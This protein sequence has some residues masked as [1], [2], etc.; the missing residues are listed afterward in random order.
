MNFNTNVSNI[1][2]S[3][4]AA[5]PL[6]M[7]LTIQPVSSHSPSI[8]GQWSPFSTPS[9]SPYQSSVSNRSYFQYSA[10]VSPISS[11]SRAFTPKLDGSGGK[12]PIFRSNH[13]AGPSNS[14]EPAAK[15]QLSVKSP[16]FTDRTSHFNNGA[17]FKPAN[18]QPTQS[19][20]FKS[21]NLPFQSPQN[22]VPKRSDQVD[23]SSYIQQAAAQRAM[24][25]RVKICTF[26]KTNG[27]IELIY[28][29]HALKDNDDK[30]TCP[31]LM[32]H[33]CPICG[34]SGEKTHT[35]KYCPVLQKQQRFEML[36]KI[37]Q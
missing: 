16:C 37:A 32:R 13:M 30:I 36:N 27:E 17:Y 4:Q 12:R 5:T 11:S 6:Y 19:P 29:S 22:R 34:A 25:G 21:E 24:G 14:S 7:P 20:R 35:R 1:S 26:C 10:F 8:G 23:M 2:Y 15:S 33:A 18:Q 28:T 3:I 9:F 31:I